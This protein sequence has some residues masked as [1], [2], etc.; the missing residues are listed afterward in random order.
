M[1]IGPLEYQ[2]SAK[3]A[4]GPARVWRPG[5]REPQGRGPRH[6]QKEECQ[7]HEK[8]GW[9][10]EATVVTAAAAAEKVEAVEKAVTRAEEAPAEKWRREETG[11]E[12]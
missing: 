8:A 7:G 4:N 1:T 6:Q 11:R 5:L 2:L 9:S 12:D 10:R 3:S